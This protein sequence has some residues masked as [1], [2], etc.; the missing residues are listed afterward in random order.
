M[1][2]EIY[3]K[4]VGK[5]AE[6]RAVLFSFESKQKLKEFYNSNAGTRIKESIVYLTEETSLE[7][8]TSSDQITLF[9]RT[10]SRVTDFVRHDQTVTP[11]GGLH[12]IQSF[13]S[14]E[15]S[16][17]KQIKCRIARQ[18]DHELYS[19]ILLDRDLEKFHIE[20][21]H[22]EDVG[23]GKG[24]LSRISSTFT[25]VLKIEENKEAE[26]ISHSRTVCIMDATCSMFHLLHKYH[27]INSNSFQIQFF[28][29]RNYNSREDKI[30]QSPSW[31]TK[32]H[33][34]RIDDA[35]SNTKDKVNTKR[36]HLEQNY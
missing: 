17:E 27:E 15:F 16:E 18:G 9:T 6:K 4:L 11:N 33:N 36:N 2:R 14:E 10:F 8:K 26:G 35:S 22:I 32:P 28:V 5:N 29:Y 31:E 1:R 19:M 30:L 24:L 12:F 21:V 7:E 34:L 13:L 20:K 3:D 23:K 25:N